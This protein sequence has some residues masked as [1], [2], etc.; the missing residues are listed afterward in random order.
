MEGSRP[1]RRR[2]LR[3]LLS[4]VTVAAIGI[5]FWY[6]L[7]DNWEQVLAADV[8]FDLRWVVSGVLFAVAVPISGALWAALL[9]TMGQSGTFSTRDAIAVHCVSWLLKYV[10]GQIGS[11]VNK[12]LWAKARG[13]SRQVVIVSFI[14]ENLMLQVASIFMAIVILAPAIGF[15]LDEANYLSVALIVVAFLAMAAFLVPGVLRPVLLRI[16]RRATRSPMPPELFLSSR[17]TF[18]YLCGFLLPRLVNA[19]GFVVLCSALFP[20]D[21]VSAA[22]VGAAYVLAGA[23][24]ILAVFVPS[25]LGVREGVLFVCLA[26]AG[27]PPALAVIAALVARLVSTLADGVVALIYLA[28]RA[29]HTKG[30]SP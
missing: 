27:F 12:V 13:V 2:T 4:V 28:L 14:Y 20:L 24:G 21:L 25:G 19:L 7:R 5:L 17:S 15:R 6:A 18:L 22:V 23:V 9:R 10:P 1:R 11:L 3:T 29:S 30:Q 8:S 26:L 16:V